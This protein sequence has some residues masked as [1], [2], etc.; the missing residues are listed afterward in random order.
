MKTILLASIKYPGLVTVIDDDDYG[1]VSQYRWTPCHNHRHIKAQ[2]AYRDEH[3]QEHTIFLHTFLMN[4][5]SGMKV[6]H[7]DCDGLNNQRSNLRLATIAQNAHNQRK[8][9]GVYTSKYKG[10]TQYQK[11]PRSPIKWKVNIGFD[12]KHHHLGYFK[13]EDAAALAYNSA[14]LKYHGEFGRPNVVAV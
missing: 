11:T 8:R 6:D 2:H 14:S 1:I 7:I 9:L 4:P 3:G 10:V 12:G 13:T 5:P